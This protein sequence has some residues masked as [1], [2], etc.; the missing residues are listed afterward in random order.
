[1]CITGVFTQLPDILGLFKKIL[2][3]DSYSQCHFL[4]SISYDRLHSILYQK[5]ALKPKC[6]FLIYRWFDMLLLQRDPGCLLAG[7]RFQLKMGNRRQK[8]TEERRVGNLDRL[9][10]NTCI[11]YFFPKRF[12]Y[13]VYQSFSGLNISRHHYFDFAR[14]KKNLWDLIHQKGRE[15]RRERKDEKQR[16][17]EQKTVEYSFYVEG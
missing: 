4:F 2:F 7:I 15:R 8:A 11:I 17:R 12:E 6:S 14:K 1:M 3:S 16:Q 9:L 10:Q 13:S 5:A